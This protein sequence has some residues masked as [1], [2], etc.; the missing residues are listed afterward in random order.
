M[1]TKAKALI[2]ILLICL[3]A[4]AFADQRQAATLEARLKES[5]DGS[6]AS[7]RI[8]LELIELYRQEEQVFGIIRTASRF[9]RS[10]ADHPQR[11][12]VI[13]TLI[14]GY[15]V[16][17]RHRDVITTGRQFLAKYSGHEVANRVRKHLATSYRITGAWLPAAETRS[18]MW[19]SAKQL[20]DGVRALK[21]FAKADNIT[22]ARGATALTL[23]MS[24]NAPACETL[25]AVALKGLEFVGRCEQWADGLQIIKNVQRRKCHLTRDQERTLHY[26]AGQ[27]ES[28]LGQHGNA[29]QSLRK[30]TGD[31]REYIQRELIDAMFAAKREPVEIEREARNYLKAYPKDARRYDP[32]ARCAHA[33]YVNGNR[34]QALAIAQEIMSVDVHIRD[35][36]SS[37]VEWCGNDY[38][39]AE[40][41]LQAAIAKNPTDVWKLR[42]I[43]TLNLYRDRMKDTGKSRKAAHDFIKHS[44]ADHDTTEWIVAHLLNS[45]ADE[46]TLQRDLDAM[47]SSARQYAHIEGYVGRLWKTAPEEKT[48]ARTW[49]IAKKTFFNDP[50]NRLWIQTHE[51]G[52]KGAQ[53]CK[54]LLDKNPSAQQREWLMLRKAHL[55][56]HHLGGGARRTA[57]RH[58]QE[59]CAAYPG[60]FEYAER[61]LEAAD[62]AETEKGEQALSAAKHLLTLPP[63]AAH[64]DTWKRLLETRNKEIVIKAAAWISQST[65]AT[66]Y[67][68]HHSTF[69]GDILHQME[70]K[71]EAL[72]W[73]RS[74]M[75]IDPDAAECISA[76]D[77]VA[78]SME[79]NQAIDFLR[80]RY[81]QAGSGQGRYAGLIAHLALREGNLGAME[82]ILID[83]KKRAT[84]Q[85]FDSWSIGDWM[86]RE[87]L[88]SALNQKE[89]PVEKRARVFA[90]V[91]DMRYGDVSAEASLLL[92]RNA[93]K[94]LKRLLEAQD[95]I[96]NSRQHHDSWQRIF[97]HA[98]AAIARE[99]H[100]LASVILNSLIHTVRSVGNQEMSQA[101]QML[102]RCYGVLGSAS[103]EIPAD[104]P[105]A[106]LLQIALHQRLGETELAEKAYDKQRAL[107]DKH[108]ND[109]PVDLVLFAAETHLNRGTQEDLMRVEDILGAW[110]IAHSESATSD[111]RDKA[112]VQ[113]LL[114]RKYQQARQYDAS[115]LEYTTVVNNF[116]DQPEAMH[117][118]FGIGETF[119]AQ[120]I[121]DKAEEVFAELAESSD[122]T[123]TIRADFLLGVLAIRQGENDK[124]RQTFLEVLGR[125]P[126]VELANETLYQLA[127]VYGLEQRYLT[128]LETLRTVG[129]LGRESKRWHTPG[130]ALSI[131]VQDT[132]LGISRG[133]TRIPVVVRTEPGGDLEASFLASGGAGKGIFLTELPTTLGEAVKKD[134]IL[135]VTGG[136][137]ITVDYPEDFK[138]EFQF[139][140]LSST[141]L[142]IS[143]DATLEAAS[144]EIIN[145]DEESFTDALKQ[146]SELQADQQPETKSA[147]RPQNQI[148]PGNFVYAQVFDGDRDITSEPDMV[149]VKLTASSGDMVVAQ[150]TESKR[151]GGQFSGCIKTGELP[152]GAK[153]SD[154]ALDHNALMAIDHS[155]ET[156]WRSEPDGAAPKSLT[157]DMKD[158]RPVTSIALTAT[159]TEN[160]APVRMHL[161]GSHDGRFWYTLAHFPTRPAQ[162]RPKLMG[163]TMR[164]HVYEMPS[165]QL[166]ADYT[167]KEV[168]DLLANIKATRV[169]DCETMDWTPPAEG[170]KGYL[171]I[172]AGNFA[173][174]RDGG[175][176]LE[177]RGEQVG[178]MLDG[179]LEIAPT[180]SSQT[181]DIYAK[182]GLHELVAF[183]TTRSANTGGSVSVGLKR[184]RENTQSELVKLGSFGPADFEAADLKLV[185][186]PLQGSISRQDKQWIL[187]MPLHSLRYVECNILEYRGEAVAISMVEITDGQN[188]HVPSANDVLELAQNN[189]LELAPGDTV[190]VSYLDELTAENRQPNRFLS[191]KL[192]ATYYN[193]KI[194]PISHDFSRAGDGSVKGARK[195]LL[196]IEPGDRIVA[197]VVDFDH[198]ISP[199]KDSIEV[200]VQVGS[201][202]AITMTATESEP[203]S[204]VFLCE[205]DTTSGEEEG[206]LT[207][208]KGDS[209]HLSYIDE[210][211]TFPGHASKRETFVLI[212]EPTEG[213]IQIVDSARAIDGTLSFTP[214]SEDRGPAHIS[215]VDYHLPLTVEVIDPDQA[216]DTSSM[217]M[218]DV[219]TTQGTT[220]RVECRLSRE[221]A[222]PSDLLE[223]TRNPALFEGRFVGQIPL[224]LGDIESAGIVPSEGSGVKG[225]IGRLIPLTPE[226][227]EREHLQT[228]G[229]PVLNINGK[230]QF[231][232]S[233]KDMSRPDGDSPTLET[234]A[235]LRTAATLRITDEQY[236]EDAEIAHVGKKLYLLLEDPDLDIS[237]QR[238]LAMIWV[239]TASGEEETVELEET[240]SHSGRFSASFPLK[241]KV[242]PVKGNSEGEIECFFGDTLTVGYLDNIAQR[243][244]GEPII[245]LELPVAVGTNGDLGAFSKIFKDED[246]AVQTRFHIAESY[247]ELFKSHLKLE[248]KE[249]AMQDLASGRRV[250]RELREDHPNPKYAPRVSYLLGQFAQE[251]E[252]WD[253]AIDAYRLIVTNHPEHELAADAQYKLGQCYEEAGQ[254]DEALES[255]VTLAATYPK[256]PLIANVML[257]IN[258]HFYTKENYEVAASVGN[259]FLERFPNHEWAPRIA[260]RVGQCHYKQEAFNQAG[261]AFDAFVKRFPE[262]ELSAQALFWSGESYRMAKNV[263]EAFRRYNRCRWDFPESEAAK[264][265]RGRLSL[266]EMLTQFEREANLTEE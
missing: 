36:P 77:R 242:A 41:G 248:R 127:E 235:T 257:R 212:N 62:Y 105:I 176:R 202:P 195:E 19:R 84:K 115:R 134:G 38:S 132:D 208:R 51:K 120:K 160:E 263:P 100:S 150:L 216:R 42:A 37:Y 154:S 21:Y 15:A 80:K 121:F 138:K 74:R 25:A 64:H 94:H 50:I 92:A 260:F 2:P 223:E 14:D 152:A 148:K 261:L 167:W 63:Q 196:R 234:K 61:W 86:P 60:N 122:P 88:K 209:V 13:A 113:L 151:H 75:D 104:S 224:F 135:Q 9:S 5:A 256:S 90:M 221:Y 142:R 58:Y 207:L 30:A 249:Q 131:V 103:S 155:E 44:P 245:E 53:A 18:D 95:L 125:L 91:R 137:T 222:A 187:D 140:F 97:A 228:A 145:T 204:G 185:E 172:W 174:Q 93:P 241:S 96:A 12:E 147:S 255:Y 52:G 173:Q 126:E 182:A 159:D 6:A 233:Y 144:S 246:L 130:N 139:E 210:Q 194:T 112:R 65:K 238:D 22:S 57:A 66:P 1:I 158:V 110:K 26:R 181:C 161:R 206:K 108:R 193:G 197:E 39:Q 219:A 178:L 35:I 23:E 4:A 170:D 82:E 171:L 109:L 237:P 33:H 186:G 76:A 119:M 29:I 141:K 79:P 129:R 266:P 236:Q 34:I 190:T 217:L 133:E 250:L 72:N 180:K 70:L 114:A 46:A 227:N 214:V 239:R 215:Q 225:G 183:A 107:F 117:A 164:L 240:L 198:D 231:T 27:F 149:P 69:I 45:V 7:A 179:R 200:Q 24:S 85:P 157:I 213:R 251:M 143:S 87:W 247:F 123:I 78:S 254:L 252:A 124:A 203:S 73:W 3:S 136:D 67:T 99:D 191:A 31:K 244:D 205:I 111:V 118:R 10:H 68:T 253:D 49:N 162:A 169:I 218:V 156:A 17:A 98:Q 220:I 20:D 199:E 54:G 81:Q 102:R 229:L 8:M 146:A 89:W 226:G 184:G 264:Y 116:G 101:R 201:K 55:Y 232:A 106:P 188:R 28:R 166:K 153:A 16:T 47:A 189:I 11:P 243:E 71:N 128:Q 163:G 56:R 259:K 262:E 265:S 59:L 43:L 32:L 168:V 192:T 258:E 211:N 230:D 175:M 83:S 40:R 48:S 165:N 177:I